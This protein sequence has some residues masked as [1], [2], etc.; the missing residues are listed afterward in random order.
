MNYYKNKK[1]VRDIAVNGKIVFLRC[2]F[3]V[4]I[5]NLG[6]ITD[7]KRI[8]ESFETINYLL[9]N[10][11]K[12]ILCSHLGR[13]KGVFNPKLSLLPVAEYIS[14]ILGET[15][16]FS[17]DSV[18]DNAKEIVKKLKAGEFRICL[19]ENIRFEPEEE[20]NDTDF[21]KKL[22]SYADV[23]INDAFGTCHR[24]HASTEAITHFLPSAYGFLIEKEISFVTK[25]LENP[26]RPVMAILGGAKVSDKISLIESL[27]DKVD[28]LAVG[29]GMTY[30]FIN[31][32][33]YKVG[34]SICESDKISFAKDLMAKATEKGV[35]FLVPVDLKVAD[36]YSE[37][38]DF[39]IVGADKIPD[40]WMGLDIGPKTT[41]IFSEEISKA[42]TIIWN[43]TLGVFEWNN[44]S[45]GTKYI[46]QAVASGGAVSLIGGG[47]SAAAVRKFGLEEKVTHISTG[48]GAF[49]EYLEK[50]SLPCL[51]SLSEK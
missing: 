31:A 10:D 42:K 51:D 13:P 22:A 24:S 3:N 8:D 26:E 18:G 27:L 47:D 49:L 50:G 7:S 35:K 38:A 20:Q 12:L 23:Y 32:L 2:D 40:S 11:A 4:P 48:G 25:A 28:I 46:A 14:D 30:T 41:E 17:T 1:S 44:F 33:G 29:G 37:N 36:E 39:K 15:V 45:S 9:E 21:A 6:K 43:G 5:D 16:G 34:D 19:L